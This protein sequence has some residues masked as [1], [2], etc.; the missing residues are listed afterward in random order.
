MT[1]RIRTRATDLLEIDHPICLAGMGSLPGHGALAGPELVAA[2]SNAGGLGVLGCT[3][4]DPHETDIWIRQTRALTNRPFGVDIVLPAGRPPSG[5]MDEFRAEIPQQYWD[6]VERMRDKYAIPNTSH[7]TNPTY[8]RITEATTTKQ[9]EV[10][11]EHKV[12]V[13]AAGLGIDGTTVRRL[14]QHGIKVMALVGSVKTARRVGGEGVDL[15]VATGTE[16]GGH[17]GHIGTFALLPQAVKAVAPVP[18]VAGGGISDGAGLAAAL[19]LGAEAVWCGTLF[20]TAEE[21]GIAPWY[22]AQVLEGRDD[23]TVQSKILTGKNNRHFAPAWE[24][25][26][27]ESGLEPL[28]MP[29]Q[30]ILAWELLDGAIQAGMAPFA[31]G[32][33]GQGIGLLHEIRPAAKIVLDMVDDAAAALERLQDLMGVGV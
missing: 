25:D 11:L 15:V 27:E 20:L 9:I 3:G 14:Q 2:V 8:T 32:R 17:G 21:S 16:G 12:P 29:L 5:G 24:R 23:S 7:P 33:A 6:F 28:P 26:W 30:G 10:V 22:R 18:V 1:V 31:G 19:A 4:M 13:F